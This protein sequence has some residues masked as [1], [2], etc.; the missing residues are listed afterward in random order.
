MVQDPD[1]ALKI[2]PFPVRT[3]QIIMQTLP[4][5][6]CKTRYGKEDLTSHS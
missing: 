3:Y 5:D 6:I 1:S 2:A 4:R